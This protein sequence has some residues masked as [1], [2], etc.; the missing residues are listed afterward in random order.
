MTPK[1]KI[2][3]LGKVNNKKNNMKERKGNIDT[4][5]Q[6]GEGLEKRRIEAAII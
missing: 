4:R 3:F 5:R 1:R 6:K 2:L